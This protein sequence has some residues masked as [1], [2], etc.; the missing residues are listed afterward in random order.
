MKFLHTACIMH[1]YNILLAITTI[2]S[3]KIIY[4]VMTTLMHSIENLRFSLSDEI[5][6]PKT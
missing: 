6:I 2:Q 1:Y 5:I 4:I 3:L